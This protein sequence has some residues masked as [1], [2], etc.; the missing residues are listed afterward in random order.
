MVLEGASIYNI[1]FWY[2][3]A[4]ACLYQVSKS[5]RPTFIVMRLIHMT[6]CALSHLVLKDAIIFHSSVLI[7]IIP[8]AVPN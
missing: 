5:W 6:T 2:L 7:S 1:R 8:C 3:R 4:P